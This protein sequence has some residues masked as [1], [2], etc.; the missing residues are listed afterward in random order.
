MSS[1]SSRKP[2]RYNIDPPEWYRYKAVYNFANISFN[3]SSL[4]HVAAARKRSHQWW[5][6]LTPNNTKTMG[7]MTCHCFQRPIRRDLTSSSYTT[8]FITYMSLQKL[9]RNLLMATQKNFIRYFWSRQ[10]DTPNLLCVPRATKAC[11]SRIDKPIQNTTES[12]LSVIKTEKSS[13]LPT[14][15]ETMK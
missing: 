2:I 6:S 1:L 13:Y 12:I 5:V 10:R 9:K 11:H 7:R 4:G 15:T 14:T 3:I 8:V